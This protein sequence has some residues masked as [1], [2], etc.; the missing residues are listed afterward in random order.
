MWICDI[1]L[2]VLLNYIISH[3]TIMAIQLKLNAMQWNDINSNFFD[4][5][6]VNFIAFYLYILIDY[7]LGK[8][9]WWDFFI[10]NLD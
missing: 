6:I 9:E 7:I 3:N 8:C 2:K 10:L 4:N 5:I 1:R